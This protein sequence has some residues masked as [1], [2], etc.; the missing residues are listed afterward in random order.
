MSGIV[1]MDR[2]TCGL[3]TF[4]GAWLSQVTEDEHGRRTIHH[5]RGEVDVPCESERVGYRVDVPCTRC[6][7]PAGEPCTVISGSGEPGDQP[8]DVRTEPHYYG[9]RSTADP[10][11]F[12]HFCDV[13]S[14]DRLIDDRDP[15]TGRS[16]AGLAACA[17]HVPDVPEL[18]TSGTT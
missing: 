2:C 4:D 18:D 15:T 5:R 3:V 13:P 8:G 1:D 16:D 6:E 7:A 9:G 10:R 14:C 17:E 12:L 11:E